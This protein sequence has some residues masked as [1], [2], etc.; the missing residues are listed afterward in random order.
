MY[1]TYRRMVGESVFYC[2]NPPRKIPYYRLGPIHF[3]H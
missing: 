3:G 2:D 1:D